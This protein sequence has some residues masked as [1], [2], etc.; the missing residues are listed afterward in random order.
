MYFNIF[1]IYKYIVKINNIFNFSDFKLLILI[2][3]KV[4]KGGSTVVKQNGV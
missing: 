1:K 4:T 3:I 2:F